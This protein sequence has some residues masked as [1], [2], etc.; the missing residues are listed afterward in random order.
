MVQSDISDM[1]K[2]DD[3]AAG[4]NTGRLRARNVY[5]ESKC[6]TIEG[7]RNR[8]VCSTK[9]IPALNSL[10]EI[11]LTSRDFIFQRLLGAM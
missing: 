2:Q 9:E 6:P 7:K 1:N 10:A 11:A 5:K 4:E 3:R 8:N